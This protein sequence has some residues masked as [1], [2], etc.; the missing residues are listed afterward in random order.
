MNPDS[1]F[2]IEDLQVRIHGTPALPA[3]VYLPGLHGDWTLI[4]S[5]RTA[6]ADRVCFVEFTYPRSVTWSLNDYAEAIGACL[7]RQGISHGWLLGESFGSQIAW[8]MIKAGQ[9]KVD[10]LVLAGGFVRHPALWGV[11]CV[12]FIAAHTPWQG[13]QALLLAYLKYAPFRHRHAPETLQGIAEFAARRNDSDW[14]AAGHRLD[15]IARNDPRVVA[16]QATMPVFYLAG[17]VDPLVPWPWVRWWLR[18][19]CSFYRG[20]RTFWTA[21]HNV[22][23]TAPRETAAQVLDWMAAKPRIGA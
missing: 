8:A 22:L 11:R 17:L 6:L 12:R 1:P 5:F 4:G 18:C 21:D 19:H 3:L 23:A 15:L 10:G 7:R 2:T 16:R 20:G 9:F 14:A 13:R